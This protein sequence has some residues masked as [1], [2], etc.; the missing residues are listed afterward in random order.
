M[1]SREIPKETLEALRRRIQEVLKN[2]RNRRKMV[3]PRPPRYDEVFF[4]GVEWL[5]R[6]G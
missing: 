4:R 2:P 6:L 5:D 1:H 3:A